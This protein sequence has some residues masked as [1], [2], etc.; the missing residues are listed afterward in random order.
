MPANTDLRRRRAEVTDAWSRWVPT[1]RA[2]GRTPDGAAA[3]PEVADSWQRSLVTV[4][5]GRHC[6]PVTD[7]GTVHPRW[8]ASPLRGPVT[9][10]AGELRSI[11]EDAG[12]I[13]AVTD[14][15]GTILW[16]CGGRVMRRKAERVNFAPGGRW[17]EPAMGTNALGLALRTGRP[18]MVFSAEHLVE[19]LHGW[20]CYCAPIHGPDGRVLGVVDLSSTWDRSHPLA[21]SAVRSVVSSIEAR[22]LDPGA[23]RPPMSTPG[24]TPVRTSA[25]APS[26]LRLTCLGDRAEGECDGAALRL[27]PRQLEILTLLAL[28]PRGFTPAALRLALW[29]DQPVSDSTLKAEVSHLRRAVGGDIANRVYA[30]SRPV[31]CDAVHVLR[32]LDTGDVAGALRHYRGPLLPRSDAPGVVAWRLRLEVATRAAVLASGT[33]EELLRYGEV[34]PDDAEV[35]EQALRRLGRHDPRRAGVLG[36]LSA[37]LAD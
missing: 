17:S 10:V 33:P 9:A 25:P 1:L 4:D 27:P 37:A 8:A 7:G 30:L 15:T 32:A 28:E 5:P 3:R 24:A 29:G 21:M 22:L 18:S 11:A 23:G 13:A 16:T 26:A 34:A 2:A 19:A 36:L 14:E 31:D 6:A 35:H 20:V 12:F